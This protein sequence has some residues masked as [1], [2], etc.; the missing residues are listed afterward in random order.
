MPGQKVAEHMQH[1]PRRVRG[2]ALLQHVLQGRL[3]VVEVVLLALHH[4]QQT[5][6]VHGYA[7]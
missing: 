7:D 1:H 4:G 2:T 5:A 3:L 6:P